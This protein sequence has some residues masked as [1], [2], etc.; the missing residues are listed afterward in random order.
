M[1]ACGGGEKAWVDVTARP[2]ALEA[3]IESLRLLRWSLFQGARSR[4]D[5]FSDE[6]LFDT[7]WLGRGIG[8]PSAPQHRR[9][10]Q[11]AAPQS[12]SA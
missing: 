4:L 8:K 1:I 5:F 7:R 11:I 9:D 2:R 12:S 10:W 3:G 6:F